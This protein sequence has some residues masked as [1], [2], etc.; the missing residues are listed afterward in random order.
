VGGGFANLRNFGG[1]RAAA[2]LTLLVL[3]LFTGAIALGA[4]SIVTAVIA[5]LFFAAALAVVT[6]ARARYH[7][8]QEPAE[9]EAPL[10]RVAEFRID[11]LKTD[12]DPPE[13]EV[14]SMADLERSFTQQGDADAPAASSASSP[15]ST[16]SASSPASTSS[17]A[18]AGAPSVITEP[19]AGK[20]PDGDG[21]AP[22]SEAAEESRPAEAAADAPRPPAGQPVPKPREGT[23]DA[24]AEAAPAA[25]E[26]D[27]DDVKRSVSPAAAAPAAGSESVTSGESE[28]PTGPQESATEPEDGRP[29]TITGPQDNAPADQTEP[30][31]P[32]DSTTGPE[33]TEPH[34]DDGSGTDRPS[35]TAEPSGDTDEA[36]P[37]TDDAPAGAESVPG[38]KAA[39]GETDG[40]A[41]VTDEPAADDP[42]T[43]S[44]VVDELDAEFDSIEEDEELAALMA[45]LFDEE[46]PKPP[47]PKPSA[48]TSLSL[49]AAETPGAGPHYAGADLSLPPEAVRD[50]AATLI[51]A[52]LPRSIMFYTEL[53]GLVEI[54]RAPDA[55]LLEAGFGRVLLWRRDDAPGAGDPVMHLTFEV[56]DIDAAYESMRA[57]GIEF[58]HPPRAALSG[59]VHNLRAASFL[60][61]D[62]HGL[63]ITELRE[64]PGRK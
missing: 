51:V 36:Q 12:D 14:N 48:G 26:P 63:A 10:E 59:E 27:G 20:A 47:L 53:L 58:T 52:D 33:T 62:G 42:E 3:S 46:V 54:D 9:T 40:P 17:A 50:V 35:G 31:R 19:V 13:A 49:L 25:T 57:K 7:F 37:A 38:P 56:G 55:V 28:Q 45:P 34:D 22:G 8:N 11:D 29:A 16:S 23:A 44:A 60:D 24:S 6:A 2:V 5:F 18:V 32:Q 30:H 39:A 41:P 61:P 4:Q 1:S 21:A 15:A 43:D 64:H